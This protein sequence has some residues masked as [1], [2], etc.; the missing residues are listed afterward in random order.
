MSVFTFLLL[1]MSDYVSLKNVSVGQG[2]L[3]DFILIF[4]KVDNC[5]FIFV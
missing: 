1:S 5:G 2:I 4:I 3:S